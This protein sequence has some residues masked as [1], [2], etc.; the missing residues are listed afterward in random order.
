MSYQGVGMGGGKDGSCGDGWVF[1]YAFVC[2]CVGGEVSEDEFD[3]TE[4]E[5]ITFVYGR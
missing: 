5:G 1:I 4:A 2:V 3:I